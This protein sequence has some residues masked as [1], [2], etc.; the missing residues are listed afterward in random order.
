M[1]GRKPKMTDGQR[2]YWEEIEKMEREGM[3]EDRSTQRKHDRKYSRK[4][5][6]ISLVSL[7]FIGWNMFALYTWVAPVIRR[8]VPNKG[9]TIQNVSGS[10]TGGGV[11]R[12][13]SNEAKFLSEVSE[14]RLIIN[15]VN[16]RVSSNIEGLTDYT[17]NEINS[18]IKNLGN[19]VTLIESY[20]FSNTDFVVYI[21][22][23]LQS[24]QN[25]LLE[26]DRYNSGVAT[27]EELNSILRKSNE[28]DIEYGTKLVYFLKEHK[29]QYE[30]R[31]DGS[32]VYYY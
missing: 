21:S 1:W 27:A 10:N 18:D 16:L 13:N 32:I 20:D 24:K 11:S 9:N 29:I 7:V 3:I 31:S 25:L 5:A 22:A 4:K 2:R 30:V 19:Y 15:D 23:L 8:Q 14:A 28:L 6:N 12:A 17:Y 26:L